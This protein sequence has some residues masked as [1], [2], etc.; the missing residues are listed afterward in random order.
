MLFIFGSSFCILHCLYLY[1]HTVLFALLCLLAY[2]QCH[3]NVFIIF[4]S[5]SIPTLVC[6]FLSFHFFTLCL[7]HKSR[8][9][10][11]AFCVLLLCFSS[12]FSATYFILLFFFG[13]AMLVLRG[14]QTTLSRR[15]RRDYES[16][17]MNHHSIPYNKCTIE[18]IRNEIGTL[19][20]YNVFF[21]DIQS[22]TCQL[23]YGIEARAFFISCVSELNWLRNLTGNAYECASFRPIY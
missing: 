21:T 3:I 1:I 23:W 2:F 6:S 20:Q 5:L 12:P 11:A 14:R 10:N 7:L 19:I 15:E 16:W 4:L 17:R 8:I 22:F 13:F 9:F 18:T